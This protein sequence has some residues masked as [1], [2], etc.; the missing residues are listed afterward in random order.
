[1]ADFPLGLAGNAPTDNGISVLDPRQPCGYIGANLQGASAVWPTAN[2]AIYI[3]IEIAVF[4]TITAI[5]VQVGTQA[6]NLDVGIYDETGTRLVSLGSTAV[7]AAGVQN[8]NIADTALAPGVYFVAMNCDSA[9]AA[10]IRCSI[11]ADLGRSV[12][13]QQQAVGA[14]ALPATATFAA[15]TLTYLPCISLVTQSGGVG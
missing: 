5:L 1:M 13:C 12:G 8:C 15:Y 10:F 7:A 11:T 14:I 4:T 3:P 6:G 9:T 2:T